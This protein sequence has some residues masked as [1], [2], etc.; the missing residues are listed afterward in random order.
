[1]QWK[2]QDNQKLICLVQELGSNWKEISTH[3]ESNINIYTER[4]AKQIKEHYLN[5]LRP[6][7]RKEDWT[8]E[9][10]LELVKYLNL[11]ETNWKALEK[12]F[13]GRTQNQ[14]KNRYFGRL[15]KLAEKKLMKMNSEESKENESEI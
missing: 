14:I 2:N 9:E 8:L 3:F 1:M 15:K 13:Q 4:N 12:Q 10:D 7:I 11:Y 6:G 5:Y